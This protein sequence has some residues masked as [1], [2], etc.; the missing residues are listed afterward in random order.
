MF[1]KTFIGAHQLRPTQKSVLQ[2]LTKLIEEHHVTLEAFGRAAMHGQGDMS[3]DIEG[4]T[5]AVWS[6]ARKL[7]GLPDIEPV[8]PLF[9]CFSKPEH[10]DAFR[11]F[12]DDY[13]D[14]VTQGEFVRE[15]LE[16]G[17]RHLN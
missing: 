14:V 11:S 17:L 13:K 8:D 5:N 15:I 9:T 1:I 3:V 4:F 10:R 16:P 6:E 12:L 7:A 2:H